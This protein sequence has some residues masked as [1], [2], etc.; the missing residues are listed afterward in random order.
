MRHC[1]VLAVRLA[2]GRPLIITPEHAGDP[3]QAD[4]LIL[5]GGPDI[6]PPLYS[7]RPRADYVYD[8]ARDRMELH[9]LEQM[10]TLN[11]PVLGICR[12]A[13]LMNVARGGG[14]HRDFAKVYEQAEYSSVLMA[15]LCYRK[16][17]FL[18]PGSLLAQLLACDHCEVNN[19]HT[20]SIA[21][22][23]RHLRATVLERNGAVQGI[24]DPRRD[25]FTAAGHADNPA[26]N[27]NW[28]SGGRSATA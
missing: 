18:Q 7:Q 5:G 24:E 10:D 19:I 25:M 12:G 20:Q 21:T 15:Q 9:W 2:G 8:H 17:V 1:L 3:Q 23:G 4:G 6:Y 14:L 11:R 26:A 16:P 13:Q 27:D 22:T 28:Q